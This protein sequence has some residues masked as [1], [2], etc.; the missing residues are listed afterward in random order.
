MSGK[1]YFFGGGL[2]TQGKGKSGGTAAMNPAARLAAATNDGE[3][4]GEAWR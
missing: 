2:L 4:T 3:E 1:G